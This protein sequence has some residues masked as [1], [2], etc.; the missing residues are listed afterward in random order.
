MKV[1][2]VVR[3]KIDDDDD[4]DEM[5]GRERSIRM[6]VWSMRSKAIQSSNQILQ[7]HFF[8]K[9]NCQEIL[10]GVHVGFK[11]KKNIYFI[12]NSFFLFLTNPT[13]RH[14]YDSRLST[15][16]TYPRP[17]THHISTSPHHHI[18]TSLQL[19]PSHRN[20]SYPLL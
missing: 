4:D 10:T 19:L 16:I 7:N 15:R 14:S 18:T 3:K 13:P 8:K 6:M 5:R 11:K 9:Q 20:Q 1:S 17:H 2:C 12:A